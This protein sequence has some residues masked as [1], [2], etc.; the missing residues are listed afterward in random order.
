MNEIPLERYRSFWAVAETQSFTQASERLYLSQPAVSQAVK[1]LEQELGVTLFVRHARGVSLTAEG[2]VLH[3]HVRE[4]FGLIN[5]GVRRIDSLR[6]LQDGE[7]RVGSSDTFSQY[8]LLPALET[9]HRHYP[10]IRLHVT[11]GTSAET[12]AGLHRGLIDFGLVNLPIVEDGLT[13]LRGPSLQQG[14]VAGLPY[15]SLAQGLLPLEAIAALPLMLLD[16]ESVTRGDL[17]KFFRQHGVRV[18]PTMELASHDL[19]VKFARAGLGVAHV[20]LPVVHELLADGTLWEIRSTPEL[21]VRRT[22]LAFVKDIPLSMAAQ[23][24][25]AQLTAGDH[26]AGPGVGV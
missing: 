10:H 18:L 16:S 6:R 19:L 24:L 5:A 4:A 9:F 12:V 23:T 8:L 3:T 2:A 20:V 21:P 7:V 13:V 1:K 25:L 26:P 11:N 17:E 15:Q 22:G 14:F